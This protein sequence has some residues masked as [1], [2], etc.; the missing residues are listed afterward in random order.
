MFSFFN[1]DYF[2]RYI[3]E[4]HEFPANTN[5]SSPKISKLD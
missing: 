5:A 3:Q 4:S 2:H 1:G